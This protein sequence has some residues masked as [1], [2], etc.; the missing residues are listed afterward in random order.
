MT[1][2]TVQEPE[3]GLRRTKPLLTRR[4][5]ELSSR[6]FQAL[7][8]AFVALIIFGPLIVLAIFSFNDSQV[9]AFPLKGFTTEWYAK[10]FENTDLREALW[11]SVKIAVPVTIICL[12]VGT[13][14]AVGLARHFFWGRGGAAGLVALPLVLP[15]LVIGISGLLFFD[16]MF[17]SLPPWVFQYVLPFFRDERPNLWTAGAMHLVVAFPLVTALVSAQ[18]YRIERNLE[19]AAMDLGATRRQALRLVILPLLVPTLAASAI[20]V[21]SWSFNNFIVS[22]FTLGF[23]TTFPVWVFSSLRRARNLPVVNAVSTMVSMVQI[24]VVWV[25]WRALRWQSERQGQDFREV[26]TGGGQGG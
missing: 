7:L 6:T 17:R 5:R 16:L 13:L 19:E 15:W 1:R 21:F 4:R 18:L 12:V 3:Q 9:L 25:A 22:F 2:P 24:L 11:N 20:F 14:A 26:L 23:E 10:A 8:L